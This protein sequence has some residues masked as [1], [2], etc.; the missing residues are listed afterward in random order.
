MHTVSLAIALTISANS[1][2]ST[3][4]E[5]FKSRIQLALHYKNLNQ[6]QRKQIWLNFIKRLK[7]LD[8]DIDAPDIDRHIDELSG[9]DMN[10]RQI[11][12]A[13]TTA[14]QLAKHK[15]QR[16]NTVHLRHVIEVSQEFEDYHLQVNA[17]AGDDEW[18]REAGLR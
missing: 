6:H 4:D 14:R 9:K 11:R 18:A 2:H 17:G 15:Q 8:E 13:I 16:L 1:D 10:G 12:N 7:S 5:A 3:F